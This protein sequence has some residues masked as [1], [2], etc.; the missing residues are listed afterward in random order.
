MAE[1]QRTSS[2]RY[3]QKGSDGLGHLIIKEGEVSAILDRAW[4][5]L[6]SFQTLDDEDDSD[7]SEQARKSIELSLESKVRHTQSSKMF[8]D[9][10]G[11]PDVFQGFLVPTSTVLNLRLHSPID[12]FLGPSDVAAYSKVHAY[13]LAIRRAHLHL[14]RLYTLSG[15]RRGPKSA[16]ARGSSRGSKQ[17]GQQQDAIQRAKNMRPL[18]AT[19]SSAVFFLATL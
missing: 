11:L 5:F 3:T 13:L 6:S 1:K 7:D 2:G 12:L 19:V 18:W 17:S 8:E 16:G 14:A 10:S 9:L 15:M 4:N